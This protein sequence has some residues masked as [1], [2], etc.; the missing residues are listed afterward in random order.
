MDLYK[1]GAYVERGKKRVAMANTHPTIEVLGGLYAA[2]VGFR[3]LL[4]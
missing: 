3:D 1:G 4:K 2:A